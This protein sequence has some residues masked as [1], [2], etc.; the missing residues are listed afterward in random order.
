MSDE[1]AALAA[2][3]AR[4]ERIDEA[5]VERLPIEEPERLYRASRHLVDAGGK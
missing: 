4:R 3:E 5:L 2:V 1:A